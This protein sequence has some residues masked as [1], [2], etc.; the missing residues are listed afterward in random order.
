M[1]YLCSTRAGVQKA[2]LVDGTAAKYCQILLFIQPARPDLEISTYIGCGLSTHVYKP[3]RL[4]QNV[5]GNSAFGIHCDYRER[6]IFK[7]APFNP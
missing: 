2:S 5:K 6:H 7:N 1:S 4:L 3:K